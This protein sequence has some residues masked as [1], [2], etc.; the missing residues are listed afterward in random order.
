VL[1]DDD[2]RRDELTGLAN[3][4]AYDEAFEREIERSRRSG[5]TLG[6]VMVDIHD[7]KVINDARGHQQGDE[8]LREVGRVLRQSCR[9]IDLPARYGGEEFAVLLPGTDLDGAYEVAERMHNRIEALEVDALRGGRPL[10]VKASFSVALLPEYDDGSECD[11]VREPRRPK[12]NRDAGGAALDRP[13]PPHEAD[14][15]K[16][17]HFR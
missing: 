7:F 1:A 3:R 2:S 9:E 16:P 5:D 6:L 14:D 4:R 8:V 17:P 12:P 11:G 15:P 10:R 13:D